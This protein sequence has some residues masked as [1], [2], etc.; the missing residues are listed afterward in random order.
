[1]LQCTALHLAVYRLLHAAVYIPK[2]SATQHIWYMATQSWYSVWRLPNVSEIAADIY[3][4]GD[5]AN[6]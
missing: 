2:M 4:L 3:A 6:D 1:M 5:R